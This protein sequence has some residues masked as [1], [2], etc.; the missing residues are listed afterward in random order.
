MLLLLLLL[1]C[2]FRNLVLNRQLWLLTHSCG[3]HVQQEGDRHDGLAADADT[4]TA[5]IGQL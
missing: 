2:C 4:A 5:V 1:L 3:F